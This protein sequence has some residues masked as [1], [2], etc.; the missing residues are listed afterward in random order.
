MIGTRTLTSLVVLTGLVGFT[1]CD[2]Q[3]SFTN[4]VADEPSA[5]TSAPAPVPPPTVSDSRG[6]RVYGGASP[7]TFAATARKK[8]AP[9]S[10]VPVRGWNV[11][12]RSPV[13][14]AA[15]VWGPSFFEESSTD[16]MFFGTTSDGLTTSADI[17]GC[18]GQCEH[19][20]NFFAVT[21]LYPM[22][23]GGN[24]QPTLSWSRNLDGGM[25]ADVALNFDGTKV[26]ALSNSGTL[27]CMAAVDGSRCAGW[28]DFRVPG[29]VVTTASPWVDSS[30][31]TNA[32]YLN[33]GAGTL[34]KVSATT[35]QLIWKFHFTTSGSSAWPVEYDGII[36]VGDGAGRL[37]R[38]VDPGASAP[39]QSASVALS[40]AHCTSPA[41][42]DGSVSID[43]RVSTVFL[44]NQGCM[45]TFPHFTAAGTAW[46]ITAAGST[47][48]TPSKTFRTWPTFDGT[49]VYWVIT[50]QTS[51]GTTE[52]SVWK[53]PYNLSSMASSPL[54][55]PGTATAAPLIWNGS[56]Y[57]GDQAGY[58][59]RFGCATS[60]TPSASFAIMTSGVDHAYTPGGTATS[61][62]VSVNSPVVLNNATGDISFGYTSD[63]GGG[64]IQYPQDVGTA[65]GGSMEWGCPT[66]TIA[67]DNQPCGVGAY[68]TKCV[69]AAVCP[70]Y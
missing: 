60:A 17:V 24:A 31:H 22:L 52:A 59:E 54:V 41:P 4:G 26:F 64:M 10:S 36:Y 29:N 55:N 43:G 18:N 67:C 20:A 49:Y 8:R 32:A 39:T 21:N 16:Q 12:T 61:F 15:A 62:G 68:Q 56:L 70:A 7:V 45:F 19:A 48:S 66:G 28:S 57:A 63:T 40:A 51:R 65:A 23:D 46:S 38:I 25:T 33:D 6:M 69:A 58:V 37:F 35:G 34:Y 1:A 9:G 13:I 14:G 42:V 50:G 47:G 2:T 30:T 11:H 27:Y 53:A 44:A 3:T 5:D